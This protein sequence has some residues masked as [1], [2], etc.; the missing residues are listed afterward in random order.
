MILEPAD[1]TTENFNGDSELAKWRWCVKKVEILVVDY[2]IGFGSSLL[3]P[4]H[5]FQLVDFCNHRLKH[6]IDVSFYRQIFNTYKFAK[7]G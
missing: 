3:H 1:G 2:E 4:L 7:N 6:K 5:N